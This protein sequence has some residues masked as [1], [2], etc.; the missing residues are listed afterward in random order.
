MAA[1][2]HG[3]V[4]VKEWVEAEVGVGRKEGVQHGVNLWRTKGTSKDHTGKKHVPEGINI[5][6]LLCS[7]EGAFMVCQLSHSVTFGTKVNA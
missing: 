2:I 1:L 4:F 5:Y 3:D 6:P 7:G